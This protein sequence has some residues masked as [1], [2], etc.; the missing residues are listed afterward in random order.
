MQINDEF[1]DRTMN[2]AERSPLLMP[3]FAAACV[4]PV[5][6]GT[7]LSRDGWP[8]T[9]GWLTI[10]ALC[11]AIVFLPGR[12]ARKNLAHL[13]HLPRAHWGAR[14][15]LVMLLPLYWASQLSTMW[16]ALVTSAFIVC[17]IAVASALLS[18][19]WMG[20]TDEELAKAGY[21]HAR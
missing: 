3:S 13:S 20:M 16:S 5:F 8:T 7:V 12:S 10:I 1:I 17:A 14:L 19:T 21:L 4:V 6:V 18:R 11:L 2:V 9:A 15:G